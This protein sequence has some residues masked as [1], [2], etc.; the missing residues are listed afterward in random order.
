MPT[1]DDVFRLQADL[2]QRHADA[3]TAALEQELREG[4]L[5][6]DTVLG[7]LERFA[8]EQ[9]LDSSTL[10]KLIRD[11]RAK[12]LRRPVH[13]LVLG[14]LSTVAEERHRDEGHALPYL[15]PAYLDFLGVGSVDA[16][17]LTEEMGA[18]SAVGAVRIRVR[19]LKEVSC[20]SCRELLQ[21]H[22]KGD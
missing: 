9:D 12:D 4:R 8:R 3:T 16:L 18:A 13:D 6:L 20:P 2:L 11:G 19:S 21:D 7:P 15:A 17:F 14:A 22:S 5:E 1:I 10:T